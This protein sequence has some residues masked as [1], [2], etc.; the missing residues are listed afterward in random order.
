MANTGNL[1]IFFGGTL[2]LCYLMNG[3][4][5]TPLERR[6]AA[7]ENTL[8]VNEDLITAGN[9]QKGRLRGLKA[10]NEAAKPVLDELQKFFPPA[11]I[12]TSKLTTTL[13][14]APRELSGVNIVKAPPMKKDSLAWIARS[15]M[16]ED[17]I[18]LY[19]KLVGEGGIKDLTP[20]KIEAILKVTRMD[21]DWELE[22]DWDSF[23]QLL[24]KISKLEYYFEVSKLDVYGVV[25]PTM[26]K[27]YR[28]P[29]TG[30]KTLPHKV[31]ATIVCTTIAFPPLPSASPAPGK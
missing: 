23:P 4:L 17:L 1:V 14:G 16:P 12:D 3:Q 5:C 7:A 20:N 28:P 18:S 22:A 27:D 13:D 6:I 11:D 9:G 31:K 21:Q 24:T 29:K 2:M 26:R 30:P 8:K 25:D 15:L 19:K 10:D